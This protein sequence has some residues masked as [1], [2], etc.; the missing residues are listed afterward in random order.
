[1]ETNYVI[2]TT[3]VRLIK[4]WMF[5]VLIKTN[6]NDIALIICILAMTSVAIQTLKHQ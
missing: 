4:T 6:P 5:L 1:M 3:T 2:F